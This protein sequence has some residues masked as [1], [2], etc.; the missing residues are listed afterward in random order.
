M[1]HEYDSQWT[2]KCNKFMIKLC[3]PGQ[4]HKNPPPPPAQ[5]FRVW[6]HDPGFIV[7]V[8]ATTIY[9]F[10][11]SLGR[12][13]NPQQFTNCKSLYMGV[14][15]I[16][17]KETVAV[18]RAMPHHPTRGS[19]VRRFLRLSIL[20]PSSSPSPSVQLWWWTLKLNKKQTIGKVILVCSPEHKKYSRV[21]EQV[22][23]Q[24]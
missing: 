14:S 11:T 20:F 16:R 10:K 22:N 2:M 24:L 1:S 8:C 9:P 5:H 3:T 6:Q 4:L 7:S 13:V 12:T 18:V 23:P 15:K 19:H 21:Q 17:S